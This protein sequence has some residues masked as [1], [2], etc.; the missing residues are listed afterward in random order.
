VAG[1]GGAAQ[2]DE[3]KLFKHGIKWGIEVDGIGKGF[4]FGLRDGCQGV[5]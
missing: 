4:D 2:F 3:F 5:L 1:K